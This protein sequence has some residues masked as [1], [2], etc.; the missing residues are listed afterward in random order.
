MKWNQSYLI[1]LLFLSIQ[2]HAQA[3][4]YKSSV[5]YTLDVKVFKDS[6]NDGTGDFNGL[7]S[8]LGYIDSLGADVIWL[9]P[10][11]TSPGKDDGYDISDFYSVDSRLGTM[12]DFENF[13]QTLKSGTSKLSSTL[14]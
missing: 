3:P 14:L 12:K 4:W 6:D 11:Q 7:T 8:R 1:V 10:F 2:L 9:A 13:V 5:I